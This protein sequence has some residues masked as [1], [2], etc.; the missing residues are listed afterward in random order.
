MLEI[1]DY[2]KNTENNKCGYI[3]RIIKKD[4]RYYY[5]VRLDNNVITTFSENEIIKVKKDTFQKNRYLT[6]SSNK[7]NIT[8]TLKDKDIFIPEIML[9]HQTL[10][11]AMT[12]LDYF[13]DKAIANNVKEVRIVHGRNGGILR[14]GVHEY[15]KNNPYVTEFR[16]G[17]YYEGS[18]GVTVAKLK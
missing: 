15:L 8:Y 16:L 17:Y 14:K 1:G 2:I 13:I 11:E 12:N 18:Y 10:E 4:N 6:N 5:V 7:E 9:R 3:E